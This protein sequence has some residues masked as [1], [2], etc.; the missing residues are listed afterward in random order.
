MSPRR[1]RAELAAP[2]DADAASGL[3]HPTLLQRSAARAGHGG[4]R[5]A[6]GPV[7]DDHIVLEGLHNGATECRGSHGAIR[8]SSETASIFPVAEPGISLL[9]FRPSHPCQPASDRRSVSNAIPYICQRH[10]TPALAAA[11]RIVLIVTGRHKHWIYLGLFVACAVAGV[12][13]AGVGQMAHD[14]RRCRWS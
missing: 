5:R 10:V 12:L 2:D 14:N 11:R 8:N 6:V 1:G 3:Q 7:A 9:R 4:E 13:A